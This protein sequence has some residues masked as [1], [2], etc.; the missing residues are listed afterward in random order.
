MLYRY[1][2]QLEI[3]FKEPKGFALPAIMIGTLGILLGRL[4]S[5]AAG[6]PFRL[7]SSYDR[8]MISM[9]L[10]SSLF[11]IGL[12]ETG[13]KKTY[14]KTIISTLLISLG[15]GQQFFNAN[16]FRRDWEKQQ[17]ILWQLYW[18]A[19]V[20]QSN[21]VLITD[22]FPVDYETDGSFTAPINWIYGSTYGNYRL[23]YAVIF[24][25]IRGEGP[26]SELATNPPVYIGIRRASF[27]GSGSQA[28]VVYKPKDGCLKILDP[29]LGD[30]FTYA[31]LVPNLV[32]VI[33]L[34]DT[35]RILTNE[36]ARMGIAFLAEPEHTWC[37]YYAKT[38]LAR[39]KKDWLEILRLMSKAKTMRYQPE[40]AFEWLPYIE[41][42]ARVGDINA[43]EQ[44][45]DRLLAED[46]RVE[47]GLCQLWARVQTQMDAGSEAKSRAQNVWLRLA[48]R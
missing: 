12:I 5:F 48:C 4:P 13:F 20:I 19:P 38:E 30:Q 10:G 44:I 43:A 42:Q 15:I 31:N 25:T 36:K 18:R 40:N 32:N 33:P 8:F 29:T 27:Y 26:V 3:P 9:M 24:T 23:D 21:T 34:S 16:I 22:E 6:L 11:I 2:T 28:V 39:Q 41:A 37:Y 1:F 17:E 14:T 7:Q 46:K 35:S 47:S 45:S